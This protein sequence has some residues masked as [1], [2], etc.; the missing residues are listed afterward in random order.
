M[1]KV[2]EFYDDQNALIESLLRDGEESQ[3]EIKKE[4]EN[5]KKVNQDCL[6]YIECYDCTIRESLT[7]VIGQDSYI[8]IFLRQY[9]AL[10]SSAVCSN[11]F[12]IFVTLCNY[13]R[14]FH[15]FT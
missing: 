12:A 10:R 11:I 15:G 7:S 2:S 13:G 14:L 4:Q 8:W 1:R 5:T 9:L 6:E 3:E